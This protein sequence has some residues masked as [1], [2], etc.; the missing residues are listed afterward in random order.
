MDITALKGKYGFILVRYGGKYWRFDRSLRGMWHL[1]S[2]RDPSKGIVAFGGRCY[3]C[4]DEN[5]YRA[6]KYFHI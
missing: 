2:P 5:Q 3:W 6:V 4:K 1:I